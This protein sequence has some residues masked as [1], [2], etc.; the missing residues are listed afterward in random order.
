M[1]EKRWKRKK[2]KKMMMTM[3]MRIRK[4]R[5]MRRRVLIETL[6]EHGLRTG[7]WEKRYEITGTE[8]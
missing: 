5:V 7:A 6:E 8:Y 2:K 3:M 1:K 4:R